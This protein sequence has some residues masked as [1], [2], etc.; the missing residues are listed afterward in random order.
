MG[1]GS[2]AL[3]LVMEADGTPAAHLTWALPYPHPGP[4]NASPHFRDKRAEQ[5]KVMCA[6][7]GTTH[8]GVQG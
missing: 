8:D 7:P 6:T 2:P 5:G 3:G 4:A 1:W